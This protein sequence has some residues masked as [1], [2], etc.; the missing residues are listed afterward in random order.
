LLF[1]AQQTT[2]HGISSL[3]LAG[4]HRDRSEDADGLDAYEAPQTRYLRRWKKAGPRYPSGY[5][6]SQA[7]RFWRHYKGPR[8]EPKPDVKEK[9]QVE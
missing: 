1:P 9:E 6:P 4:A 7:R 2:P 3:L 5:D 8:P